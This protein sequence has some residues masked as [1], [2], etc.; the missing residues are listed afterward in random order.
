MIVN[1]E[2]ASAQTARSEGRGG[3]VY[4][5]L[6]DVG[7]VVTPGPGNFKMSAGGAAGSSYAL[8]IQGKTADAG[9][10]AYV[11]LGLNFV[12]PQALYDAS[13]YD[14]LAFVARRGPGSSTSLRLKLPD[15]ST[16]P[17]GGTCKE[18]FNDFGV[19]FQLTEEWTRYVVRFADLK[20]MFGWGD[21]RPEHVDA[22]KLFGVQFQ[23]SQAGSDFDVWIDDVTFTGCP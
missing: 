7:S 13:R 5:Y 10:S 1:G 9:D 17:D 16:H 19:D 21:P 11:G 4:A 23:V 22:A 14:G 15:A 20:Q 8:R 6:D 2:D 12:D 18:C 3:Y